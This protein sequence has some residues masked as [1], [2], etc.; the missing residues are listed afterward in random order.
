MLLKLALGNQ[1]QHNQIDWLV[2]QGIEIDAFFRAAK[3]ADYFINQIG[4]GMRNADSKP[5]AGAH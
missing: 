3:R 5:D 4:G 2:I 1:E